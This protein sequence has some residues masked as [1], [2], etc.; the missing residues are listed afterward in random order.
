MSPSPKELLAAAW[1]PW[2]TTVAILVPLLEA[3]SSGLGC[4]L[5]SYALGSECY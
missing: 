5:Q 1:L 4:Q 3:G 2:D